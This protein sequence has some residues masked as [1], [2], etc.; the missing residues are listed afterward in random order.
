MHWE[1]AVFPFHQIS[2]HLET[3]EP[4]GQSWTDSVNVVQLSGLCRGSVPVFEG[5]LNRNS[6]NIYIESLL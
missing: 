1:R 4:F 5:K 6:Y 2:Q 3:V